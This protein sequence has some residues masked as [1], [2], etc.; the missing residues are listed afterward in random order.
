VAGGSK[1]LGVECNVAAV[2]VRCSRSVLEKSVRSLNC[3]YL[4]AA[5]DERR[6]TLSIAGLSLRALLI[7]GAYS[8]EVLRDLPRFVSQL[9]RYDMSVKSSRVMYFLVLTL[10]WTLGSSF[11]SAQEK[12]S[13]AKTI[14]I[15][16]CLQKGDEA[17]EFAITGE[18]GKKY[19]LTSAKVALKEHVGHQVTVAGTLKA[20]DK[21]EEAE[22]W[23]G[24][25]RVTNVKMI[26]ASCK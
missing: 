26:S 17:N 4:R 13:K 15:T 7:F 2:C 23:A 18:D 16:G 1:V 24:Q 5:E 6:I 20:E 25:V 3:L 19:E 22:G 10:A 14:T 11:T 8:C 12:E 21:K 9:R